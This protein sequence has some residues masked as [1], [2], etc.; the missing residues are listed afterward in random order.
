MAVTG[1]DT[2]T[3]F[4]T[5]NGFPERP[6]AGQ[7]TNDV[8]IRELKPGTEYRIQIVAITAEGLVSRR[9]AEVTQITGDSNLSC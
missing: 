2:Y 4:V 8:T 6:I 1:A 7:S 5:E 9:S 3:V